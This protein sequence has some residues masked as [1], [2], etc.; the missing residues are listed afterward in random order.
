MVTNIR[1]GGAQERV[2]PG[3]RFF[4]GNTVKL[5]PNHF[6]AR[7]FDD[8]IG[9]IESVES[10]PGG[11]IYYMVRWSPCREGYA[12]QNPSLVGQKALLPVNN[13]N[14]NMNLD[15]GAREQVL[16]GQLYFRGD[17]VKIDSAIIPRA[18]NWRGTILSASINRANKINYMVQWDQDSYP[19]DP[20]YKNPSLTAQ[21]ILLPVEDNNVNMQGGRRKSRRSRRSRKTRRRLR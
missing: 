6:G 4:V 8:C 11:I 13:N 17:R 1:R 16:P 15:G 18:A 9:R 19:A 3:Q 14:S 2:I 5:N 20:V 10:V 12:L 7:R 21:Q